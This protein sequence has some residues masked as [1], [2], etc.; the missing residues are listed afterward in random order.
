VLLISFSFVDSLEYTTAVVVLAGLTYAT[1]VKYMKSQEGF[2]D[3]N[4][5]A[6]IVER[7]HGWEKKAGKGGPVGLLSVGAEGFADAK[8]KKED[9]KGALGGGSGQ[10]IDP[11]ATA[12]SDSPPA[13]TTDVTT[14]TQTSAVAA[15]VTANLNAKPPVGQEPVSNALAASDAYKALG[16]MSK[17]SLATTAKS[18]D[19]FEGAQGLFKLGQ[20]PSESKSG[21]FVDVAATMG[22]A[23]NALQPEQMA[24]MTQESQKLMETQK[25][26]MG[27]LQSM[28]PVL[29]VGRQ[30]LDTLSGIFGGGGKG[31]GGML[32]AMDQNAG[33]A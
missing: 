12:D 9:E 27:M 15:D 10:A 2:N 24:A 25:S 14:P 33:K 5:G 23:I 28:R 22:N 8:S 29:Q 30:L 18:A 3:A 1:I 19:G 7:V 13:S 17:E 11:V 6:A 26:L 32:P 31:L 4:T 21:P 16:T 20:M